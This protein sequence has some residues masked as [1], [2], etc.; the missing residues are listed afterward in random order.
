MRPYLS[1]AKTLSESLR[2]IRIR[3]GSREPSLRQ[4]TGILTP[5]TAHGA[6]G[7]VMDGREQAGDA[8]PTAVTPVQQYGRPRMA[9]L[10]GL[11]DVAVVEAADFGTLHEG[12]WIGL[13]SGA[14]LS[15]ARCVRV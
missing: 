4:A 9:E 13:R 3:G 14:S 7:F 11:A 10:R 2:T 6:V 5:P 8:G 1:F 15:S 12:S